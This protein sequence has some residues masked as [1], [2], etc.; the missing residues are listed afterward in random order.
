M[1]RSHGVICSVGANVLARNVIGKI[2]VN[3]TPLTA[4]M[5]RSADPARMPIQIMAKP[6]SSSSAKPSSA[7]GRPPVM[8]Q[9]MARPV[10]DMTTMPTLEWI[11]L[12]RLRPMS[13]EAREIG[14]ERNRSTMPLSMSVLRPMA[15]TK[16]EKAIVWAMIPGSSHSR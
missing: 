3:I 6:K 15:T 4:S 10:S 14:S 11:R 16:D 7:S 9:P 2:V 13:T 8:R 5:D 1:V 12:E